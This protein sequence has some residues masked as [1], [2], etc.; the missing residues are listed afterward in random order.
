MPPLVRQLEH[1]AF[2]VVWM[3]VRTTDPK[4]EKAAKTRHTRKNGKITSTNTG[5]I[6]INKYCSDSSIQKGPTRVAQTHQKCDTAETSW[7]WFI[8]PSSNEAYIPRTET[9]YTTCILI[10]LVLLLVVPTGTRN[11]PTTAPCH[12]CYPH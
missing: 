2:Y 3:E 9:Q 6:Q 5:N 8:Y 7:S 11:V 10:V 4:Y 1:V 12:F